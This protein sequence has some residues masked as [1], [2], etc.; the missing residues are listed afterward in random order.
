MNPS[1]AAA[2]AIVQG[3]VDAGVEHV[4]LCP[5]S[6]SAPL[7]YA[8]AAADDAGLLRVHVRIDERSAGFT[9]LG[10][11]KAGGIAAVVTTSGTAVAN[12]LPAVWEAHHSQVALLLL[13]ADRPRRLRGT[14]ANQTTPLQAAAFA[15][16]A[17]EVLDVEAA[18]GVDLR[19][20]VVRL[21]RV[22]RADDG[23]AGG[24]VHVNAG[25]DDPLVPDDLAW[26]PG[27]AAVA[28]PPAARA[29]A[30]VVLDDEPTLVVAGDGAGRLAPLLDAEGAPW[31]VEASAGLGSRLPA[32]PSGRLL[33]D[34]AGLGADVRRV[35][36]VGRPTLTRPV[37]RLVQRE[38]VEVVLVGRG[39]LPGPGRGV[40]R[41]EAASVP[42]D[43][44]WRDRW[45]RAGAAALGAVHATL[46]RSSAFAGLHVARCVA[47]ARSAWAGDEPELFVGASSIV[48]DLDLVL[49]HGIRRP[50]VLASRGLAGIDG[51]LSTAGGI[52]LGGGAPVRA[53]VGDLT[54]LH[55]TNGLLVGH[56]EE[57]P[58]VQ[59]VVAN[60]DGGSIFGLLEHGEERFAGVHERF[61]ATPHGVD[62]A[63]LCR[64]HGVPHRLVTTEA[65]LADALGSWDGG[66]MEVVEARTDRS[67]SRALQAEVAAAAREAALATLR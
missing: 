43:L 59:V 65:E 44:P 7:A 47:S 61:F 32:V 26:S 49:D 56:T 8:L 12:L 52:A 18:E 53:L 62:L 35:V 24:P 58:P 2:R 11:G 60:D 27:A 28:D 42:T 14:W 64:A 10:I 16:A 63:S 55:D 5:G 22:A 30:P 67:G 50:P 9:A 33:V 23:G 31:C 13:T 25:F 17:L 15:E 36:V 54:F 39:A 21:V 41:V 37:S 20:E 45:R 19:A 66:A 51:S 38:D 57:R 46:D 34:V 29:V 1:T 48:R 3:L 6:R 4:V 40:R